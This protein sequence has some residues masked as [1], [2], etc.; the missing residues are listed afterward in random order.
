MTNNCFFINVSEAR[1]HFS[2][3]KKQQCPNNGKQPLL[4]LY[5]MIMSKYNSNVMRLCE[6]NNAYGQNFQEDPFSSLRNKKL[7]TFVNSQS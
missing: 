2:Q 5:Q 7:Q 6:N 1:V 3:L 4:N